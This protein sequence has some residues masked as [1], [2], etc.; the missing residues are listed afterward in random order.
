M[1]IL[2][3]ILFDKDPAL[4]SASDRLKLAAIYAPWLLVPLLLVARMLRAEPFG[5]ESRA[6]KGK[7]V[8]A[9]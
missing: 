5:P 6:A 9:R 1:P 8:K 3:H 2:G 4:G 7:K